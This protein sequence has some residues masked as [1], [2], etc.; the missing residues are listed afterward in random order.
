MYRFFKED[1]LTMGDLV[2][3]KVG[4][5]GT[6]QTCRSFKKRK[7]G[8]RLLGVS[9]HDVVK[10]D[11]EKEPVPMNNPVITGGKIMIINTGTIVALL[12]QNR[13]P[14]GQ[15]IYVSKKG[16]FTWRNHGPYIGQ[17]CSA[18]DEDGY[19]K[20]ALNITN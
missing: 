17:T 1:I 6:Y 8:D 4:L 18:Q 9:G 16:K 15:A 2:Y 5:S 20:I 13:I 7:M 14:I 12:K 3:G 11:L 19:V 10:L